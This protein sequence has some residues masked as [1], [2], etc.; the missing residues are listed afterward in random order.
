TYSEAQG[1][2]DGK[3]D[4]KLALLQETAM[5]PLW[6]PY[7]C[8]V[9]ARTEPSPLGPALPERR[10]VNGGGGMIQAIAFRGRL[11]SMRLIEEFMIMANVAAAET[12]EKAKMPLIY[13]VHEEPSKEKV[14][15][16]S[17][18]LRTIGIP[19]AKGQVMKPAVFN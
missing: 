16:F 15:A 17:E 1:S 18:Y 13:R 9:Q 8:L 11:E 14:V 12:L 4:K 2:F 7:S 3:P 6:N 19:F 5:Q 10:R